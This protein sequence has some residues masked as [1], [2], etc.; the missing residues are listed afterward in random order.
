MN[1]S[2]R[3]NEA[4]GWNA[5]GIRLLTSAATPCRIKNDFAAASYRGLSYDGTNGVASGVAILKNQIGQ[6]VS[7]HLRLR[8]SDAGG[9]FFWQNR[10][11]N[12]V[13]TVNPFTDSANAPVHFIH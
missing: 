12:G 6:G 5:E 11:T 4:D 1:C 8:E 13:T 10:F 2:R 7:Y 9:F 3:G